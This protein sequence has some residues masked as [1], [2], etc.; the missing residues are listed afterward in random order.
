MEIKKQLRIGF[1][2][3]AIFLALLFLLLPFFPQPSKAANEYAPQV[4]VLNLEGPIGPATAQYVRQGID[5]AE[6]ANANLIV[7][8]MDTPGGLGT[9]MRHI[10]Q[11]ILNSEVPVAG[12]VAPSG[13][14]AASAGTFI[15]YACH[16]AAMAP[17]TN[18]G[19]A[20]PVKIGGFSSSSGSKNKGSSKKQTLARKATNDAVAYIRSLASL[21]GR[22]ADWAEKA[23]TKAASL[24]VDQAL[25]LN[26]INYK[27]SNLR[28]LLKKT[29]QAVVTIDDE[30]RVVQT[31]KARIKHVKADWRIEFLKTI[32]NPTVAYILLMIGV[33]GIFFE[34]A[35]PGFIAPGVLGAIA[36]LMGL[37]AMQLLPVSY[38]G[39]AL[40]IAGLSFMVAEVFAPS[41]G[42]LGIGGAL[43]FIIGTVMLFD[44]EAPGFHMSLASSLGL[45]VVFGGTF[46]ALLQ[47]ALR[48]YQKPVETGWE[49][50]VGSR[51]L[52][53]L[54][55]KGR[56]WLHTKGEW[57]QVQS[58]DDLGHEDQVEVVKVEGLVLHVRQIGSR[59]NKEA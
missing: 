12:Y 7:L 10:N 54:D 50:L 15:M 11:R 55:Y 56:P 47:L 4:Y 5:R 3:L 46:L 17:G 49:N 32:T 40:L 9:S 34:F 41:F 8:R 24:S 58:K 14:R 45:S 28:S 25:K 27:A 42:V 53:K 26:V 33:Y 23:V 2:S 22:N 6:Q 16:I 30:Q 29:N 36:L 1:Y 21:R 44:T 31:L 57:W 35:N 39:L 43:A 37:Y 20:S 48:S 51:G 59:S 13:A 38:A 19:A 52:I 18:L